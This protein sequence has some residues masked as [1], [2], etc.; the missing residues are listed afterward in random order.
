MNNLTTID[1]NN[2]KYRFI[3]NANYTNNPQIRRNKRFYDI[4]IFPLPEYNNETKGSDNWGKAEIDRMSLGAE[5]L[6][7]YYLNLGI[8][9]H[10]EYIERVIPNYQAN[11][12]T[13]DL[14]I[15]S[16]TNYCKFNSLCKYGFITN[17]INTEFCDVCNNSIINEPIQTHDDRFIKL[18]YK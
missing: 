11:K 6:T 1:F 15:S 17:N 12:L 14:D 13:S 8:M 4:G 10:H 18:K 16:F 2:I 5:K 9:G 3:N 7:T